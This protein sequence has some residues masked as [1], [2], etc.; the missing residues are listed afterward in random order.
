MRLLPVVAL[1]LL[2][3]AGDP[4][5]DVTYLTPWGPGIPQLDKGHLIEFASP[6]E[7]LIFGRDGMLAY[8]ARPEHPR[9]TSGS[10]FAAVDADGSSAVAFSYRDE[11][12]RHRGG[13]AFFD[14]NGKQARILE[15]GFSRACAMHYAPTHSLWVIASE[16]VQDGHRDTGAYSLRR[17]S[18]D[19]ELTGRFGSP[20][21]GRWS[22]VRRLLASSDRIGLWIS[23]YPRDQW[24]EID[25][26]G[27]VLGHWDLGRSGFG[28]AFTLNSQLYAGGEQNKKGVRRILRFHRG[29][30]TWEDIGCLR[31]P[32]HIPL[33][34]L[35]LL[36]GADEYDL[37]F[38]TP[39]GT[40]FLWYPVDRIEPGEDEEEDSNSGQ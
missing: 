32:A 5:R 9:S 6:S 29:T 2:A 31:P 38:H 1:P 39:M 40:R 17:Y 28:I 34:R 22:S 27:K 8:A 3:I 11:Q 37:V 30:S 35:D 36:M 19:G 20:G 4:V 18:R 26:N 7:V 14:P 25:F 15:L 24:V 13:I 33:A 23:D 16:P 21:I 10:R 12:S